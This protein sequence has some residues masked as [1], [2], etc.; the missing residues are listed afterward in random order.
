LGPTAEIRLLVGR[1]LRRSV[2][3]AKG[4][5][6]GVVTLLGAVLTSFLVTSIEGAD[7]HSAAGTLSNEQFHELKRQ[8][9][10]QQ[11]GNAA[12]AAQTA[13]MPASLKAFLDVTIWLAPLLIA[14]LGFDAVAGE[15]QH[16]AVR[17]W[18]VRVRR[19]SYFAGKVL[20]LWALVALVTL[21]IQ[22]IAGAVAFTRGYVTPGELLS[23]SP[24]FWIVSVLI[25]GAWAAIATLVSSL[26]RTP[27]VALLTTF[28]TFFVLWVFGLSAD[29]SRARELVTTQ[30]LDTKMR[31]YEYLYPNAY[32]TMLLDP[33]GNKV[34]VAGALL[35]GF[36]VCATAAGALLFERRDL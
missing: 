7:R 16:R 26:F 4:I 20:G 14:L 28:A 36:A 31:W 19:S 30:V 29:I 11:T 13:A 8:V 6:L 33:E 9:V 23:W 10:E 27:V 17:F 34:L 21:A 1:E 22:T 12:F 2:R 32:K 15:L 3:S 35:I 24:R 18:T 5:A 25:A